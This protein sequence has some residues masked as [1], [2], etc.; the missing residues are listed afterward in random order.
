LRV[1]GLYGR[2]ETILNTSPSFLPTVAPSANAAFGGTGMFTIPSY[3]PALIDY[4]ARYGAAAGCAVGADGLP[5]QP[6]LAF[7][8]RFRPVLS[9][10]NPLFD[11]D[12]GTAQ[13]DYLSD[14]YQFT[15]ELVHD[16]S[17]GLAVTAGATWSRYH[18]FYEVGDSYVDLLQ[19]ALAGFGGESC[20]YASPQ[21]RAGLSTAQ[22]AA[23]AGTQGCTWF[24]PFSTA[25]AQNLVTGEINPQYAGNGSSA[26]LSTQPGAGLVNDAATFGEIYNVWGRTVT[27]QQ[28]VADLVLAGDTGVRLPG[29]E[30]RF[31][32]GGQYRRD[33]YDRTFE[34]G[35]NL[36]QFPCP[37]SVLNPAETCN[38]TP[39]A[40]GFI[41]AGT[42]ESAA[43]GVWALFAEAQLPITD[44]LD[45][46]L[47]ARLE[48]YGG[49]VGATFDPQFRVRYEATDWLTLRGGVGTTFRAP[50][51][52]QG[53]ADSVVLTFIGGAFRAVDLFANPLLEPESATTW[54][55][56][57]I[58]DRGGFRL[59]LDY[60][61]YDVS[62]VI[63]NEPVAGIVSAL[64]GASGSANCGRPEY[65]ALQAR[66]TFSGGTCGSANVQRLATYAA[67][68]GDVTT[69]GLDASASHDWQMGGVALQAGVQGSYVI[70]YDMSDVTVEGVLVQPS[71][72]A[73][74]KLNFQ[75][76][77]YPLPRWKGQA[78]VQAL[79]GDHALRVQANHIDSYTDQRGA[80]V[81]GPNNG[82]L[83]G[84]SVT[85]GKV[86]GS[87]TTLDA[88]WR[89]AVRDE[90]TLAITL[91]N[92]LD[93]AP[94]LAR[95]DQNFDPFTGDPLGFTVKFGVSKAF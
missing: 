64:F 35:T 7:P 16:L 9:G 14:A 5:T 77:A 61:R 82:A 28:F 32:A 49:E 88:T 70:E 13:L 19:N 84:G 23:I 87:F 83:A 89:W 2:T 86:I 54:N 15:G 53:S 75:T 42:D 39:G 21:S 34:G 95:L 26:G 43:R 92:I 78:W 37:G 47:S 8:V 52:A 22:L 29:G 55:A 20:A 79:I 41:G 1:T 57:A 93:Q 27:T 46:Q 68:L 12:R 66:F 50:P 67:N 48:N 38:P 30:V 40:L 59:S 81:F 4:C 69:S 80:D 31:A 72:D 85:G 73:V 71:F 74:G 24:N 76:S 56:G 62:G 17:P 58:V 25:I 3:A 11:N 90:T 36:D 63:E 94:P 18:R 33:Y 60:W 91:A 6:A 45:A 51:P 65:A 10:G 44:R